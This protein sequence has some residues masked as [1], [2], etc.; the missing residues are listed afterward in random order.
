[1]VEFFIRI[2]VGNK[3]INMEKI[4]LTQSKFAL[5]DDE[6]YD[7]LNQWKWHALKNHR[8]FTFYAIKREGKEKVRMH[9]LILGLQKGDGKEVDHI[10]HNG[11]DNRRSNL[12]IVSRSENQWNRRNPKGYTW[13]ERTK[14][15]QACIKRDRRKIHLGYFDTEQQAHQAYLD[16]KKKY[17][18]FKR[19]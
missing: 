7:W 2:V 16:A 9:R 1:M 4:T 11:L 6:D 8:D 14:K 13:W 10:N 5:V 18:C 3:E 19:I 15:W 17:H 12:R